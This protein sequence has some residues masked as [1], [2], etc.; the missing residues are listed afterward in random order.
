MPRGMKTPWEQLTAV[1]R[2]LWV[3]SHVSP[4]FSTKSDIITGNIIEFKTDVDRNKKFLQLREKLKEYNANKDIDCS[5]F[6]LNNNSYFSISGICGQ[7][8]SLP[9]INKNLLN[10]IKEHFPESCNIVDLLNDTSGRI[11]QFDHIFVTT[12]KTSF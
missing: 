1:Q 6:L 12:N 8:K 2:K 11:H 10:F 4:V 7:Y 9:T 5:F 3:Q